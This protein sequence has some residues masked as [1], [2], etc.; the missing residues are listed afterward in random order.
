VAAT[1]TIY[2]DI[3][4]IHILFPQFVYEFF[5]VILKTHREYLPKKVHK[6]FAF[7]LQLRCVFSE[8]QNN[9]AI[10]LL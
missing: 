3:N 10:L 7:V 5:F 4:N 1:R 2:F 8:I 6:C 9:I